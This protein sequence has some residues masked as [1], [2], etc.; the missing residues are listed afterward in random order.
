MTEARVEDLRDHRRQRRHRPGVRQPG[1][2]RRPRLPDRDRRPQPRP[3]RHRGR[4]DQVRAAVVPRG[5]AAVRL[6]RPARRTP[7]GRGPAEDLR[8]DRRPRQQRRHGVLPAPPHR[9]RHRVD[10]RDQP[11]RRLPAHRAAPRPARGERAGTGGLHLVRGPLL[12]DHGPRRPRLRAGLLDHEGLR[13]LQ[14]GQRAHRAAPG[15]AA[16]GHGCHRHRA[17][18]RRDRHQHLERRT[19]VRAAGARRAQALED[20]DAG[21]RRL[22]ARLPRHE[23]RGRGTDRRLLRPQPAARAVRARARRRPRRAAVRRERAPDRSRRDIP[24]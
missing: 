24:A 3:D 10:V 22:P 5:L 7:A 4:P 19:V 18:P 20:G 9:R 12:R 21:G 8:A 1:G 6:R 23:S 13:P 14:A 15:P 16:R 11:P 17:A 2:G